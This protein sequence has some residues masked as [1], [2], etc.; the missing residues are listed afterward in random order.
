MTVSVGDAAAIGGKYLS[1]KVDDELRESRL[2]LSFALEKRKEYLLA[3]AN[4]VVPH[5]KIE[6]FESCVV[7]IYAFFV[8]FFPIVLSLSLPHTME[9]FK[10]I[11]LPKDT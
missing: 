3:H 4:D 8:L 1:A 6:L 7:I 2:L 10:L 9:I 11:I 5:A